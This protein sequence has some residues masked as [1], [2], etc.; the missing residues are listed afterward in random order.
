MSKA[1]YFQRNWE[2]STLQFTIGSWTTCRDNQTQYYTAQHATY[3]KYNF[4]RK[5][6]MSNYLFPHYID[7]LRYRKNTCQTFLQNIESCIKGQI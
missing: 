2:S 5:A 6:Q 1:L 3:Y 4:Y 7:S